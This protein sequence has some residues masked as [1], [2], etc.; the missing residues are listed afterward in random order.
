MINYSVYDL[1]EEFPLELAAALWLEIELNGEEQKNPAY[2]DLLQTLSMAVI[3]GSIKAR[4]IQIRHEDDVVS[5]Q[6]D[7]SR[8]LDNY[9][10][11][12]VY[13]QEIAPQYSIQILAD[14]ESLKD[15]ACSKGQKPKF[16]FPEMR[17]QQEQNT[18]E[19]KEDSKNETHS[20]ITEKDQTKLLCII[21]LLAETLADS[22]PGDFRKIS[23]EIVIGSG[24]I[25][26]EGKT[27]LT[28]EILEKLKNLKLTKTYGLGKSTLQ[29]A[30]TEGLK[31][32]HDRK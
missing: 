29:N 8:M 2:K 31:V 15:F 30:I 13:R 14:R 27:N 7:F 20:D 25:G 21:G 10:D 1:R 3:K 4:K 12:M 16:L 26:I 18:S 17:F 11:N 22:N 23:G 19:P 32:L 5:L 28:Y 6:S 9:V 24:E